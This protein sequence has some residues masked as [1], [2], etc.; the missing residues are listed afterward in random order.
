M[1]NGLNQQQR[2]AVETLSGPLLV[3]AGAGT[4]K[5]RVVTHRIARLIQR[6]TRPGRI[7]AVTF[8]NKAANEM[9]QR[10]AALLGRRQKERPEISTFH[11]LCVRVLRRH[12]RRLGLPER[13]AIF[14]RSEQERLARAAMREIQVPG[15][16]LRPGDLLAI[17]SSWKSA[18][19]RPGDASA[20]ARTDREH[21]AAAAYRRYQKALEAQG[22]VDFDDLLL[23]TDDLF[24]QFADAR[25]A[26]AGRFDH[27]L[28]DEYQDTNTT[29]Y[30]LVRALAVEHRNLC[31]V[32]DDDQSIYGWRGADVTHILRFERDWP[33]AKVVRL[34]ENYRSTTPILEMANRLIANN[35]HRHPKVLRS[36]RRGGEQPRILTFPDE[37][38]EARVIVD[39]IAAQIASGLV[40]PRDVAILFRTNQQPRSFESELRRREVPYVLVGGMSFFDRKEVR[41]VLAFFRVVVEPSDESALLRIINTPPRGLGQGTVQRLLAAAV[42]RRV[43]LW[44]LLIETKGRGL[45]SEAARRGVADLVA[46]VNRWRQQSARAGL[47]ALAK[48]VIDEVGYRQELE[49]LYDDPNERAARLAAVEDTVNAVA[50]YA[51][52]TRQPTLEGFLDEIALSGRDEENDKR[53]KLNR[54]AVVLMTLHS[55]KGLEFPRV[56]LVGLE[57][58]ILPHQ[59]SIDSDRAAVDEERRLCYVGITR[60]QDQL[61]LSW[62]QTR[63]KWGKPRPTQPSRFLLEI[64]ES[65][66]SA[67]RP[68]SEK[69]RV[70]AAGQG[71]PPSR[72]PPS[73]PRR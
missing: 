18:A 15:A 36:S 14:D 4:G 24:R 1:A 32:G 9:Q 68:A 17:I 58:G 40:P 35:R 70:R 66:E 30:Q 28:I 53:A 65:D 52:R 11:S 54:D 7:L 47:A 34:E 62:S 8:T 23:R 21:L 20:N 64:R 67:P 55:A 50:E 3:L 48:S 26:E 41:D 29:Q 19:V 42:E 63:F 43:P 6:G 71:R 25:R 2:E 61:T 37:T 38:T 10:A 46:L 27:V 33:G 44:K 13:F 45:V 59:R 60:A 73:R 12:A 56:Y 39:E 51:R 69:R 22:A 5:T 72:R 49:R 31:V 57:E 16:V